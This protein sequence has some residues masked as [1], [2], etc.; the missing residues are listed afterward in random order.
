MIVSSC[1]RIDYFPNNTRKVC[2][3]K[4][5]FKFTFMLTPASALSSLRQLSIIYN[6]VSANGK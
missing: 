2:L 3:T 5:S 1:C 4:N 6:Q